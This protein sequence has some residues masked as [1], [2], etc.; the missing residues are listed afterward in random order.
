MTGDDFSRAVENNYPRWARVTGRVTNVRRFGVF[1]KFD[2]G[3]QGIIRRRELTWE[4]DARP[5][6]VISVGQPIEVVVVDAD[7]E[8]QGLELSLR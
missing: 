3:V 8:S 5:R 1:V 4:E 6:E 2:D 7:Y